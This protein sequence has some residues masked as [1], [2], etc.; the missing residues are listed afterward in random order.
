MLEVISES[1]DVVSHEMGCRRQGDETLTLFVSG[2]FY[3]LKK[4]KI[5]LSFLTSFP[6]EWVV[7]VEVTR[8]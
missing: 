8:L 6:T 7:A 5:D 4:E 2:G 1:P 3:G